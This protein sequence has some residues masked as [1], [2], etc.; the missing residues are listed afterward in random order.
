MAKRGLYLGHIQNVI[1]DTSKATLKGKRRLLAKGTVQLKCAMYAD[2]LEPARQLSLT[3]QKKSKLDIIEQVEA[4]ENAI[5][6]YM[7][8]K[9]EA[10]VAL[11]NK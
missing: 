10:V 4:D 9:L 8:N 1:S 6:K 2:I 7:Q 11:S 3:T 5:R